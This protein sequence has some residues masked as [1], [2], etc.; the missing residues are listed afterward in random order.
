MYTLADM[1][2]HEDESGY[3][4]VTKSPQIQKPIQ[5]SM[6]RP[7]VRDSTP[8]TASVRVPPQVGMQ[9]VKDKVLMLL[10][11]ILIGMMLYKIME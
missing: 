1:S 8:S 6:S 9:C 10:I 5:K 3:F 7:H 11:T 4:S 2:N